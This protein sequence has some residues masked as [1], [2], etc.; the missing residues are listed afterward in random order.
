MWFYISEVTQVL[1]STP[2]R[3]VP[4][5]CG[6]NRVSAESMRSVNMVSQT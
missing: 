4:R 1:D 6:E 2:E 3:M 5:D